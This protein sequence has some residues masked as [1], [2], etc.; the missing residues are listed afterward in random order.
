MERTVAGVN[1]PDEMPL[2]L[3][4]LVVPDFVRQVRPGQIQNVVFKSSMSG[5]PSAVVINLHDTTDAVIEIRES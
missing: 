3:S 1:D 4:L 2:T 5:L